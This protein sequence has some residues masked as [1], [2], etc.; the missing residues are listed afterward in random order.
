MIGLMGHQGKVIQSEGWHCHPQ[1]AVAAVSFTSEGICSDCRRYKVAQI[2]FTV[3][4]T[5]KKF[6]E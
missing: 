3:L 2:Y 5:I 4:Y 6:L 1:I